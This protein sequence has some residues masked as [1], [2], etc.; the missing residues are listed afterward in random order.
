MSVQSP[1][2]LGMGPAAEV[3]LGKC[4]GN[5]LVHLKDEKAKNISTSQEIVD[6]LGSS[7]PDF[8]MAAQQFAQVSVDFK[9]DPIQAAKALICPI[10]DGLSIYLAK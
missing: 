6:L 4:L 10:L 9:S 2:S 5:I 3:A 8:L 7:L 1:V